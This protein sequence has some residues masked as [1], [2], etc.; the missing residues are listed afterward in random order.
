MRICLLFIIVAFAGYGK[1][2]SKT[3]ENSFREITDFLALSTER[4]S[5]ESDI[6]NFGKVLSVLALGRVAL[7]SFDGATHQF[8]NSFKEL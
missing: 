6:T 5:E 7:N 2:I 3:V 4:D 1:S 8:V